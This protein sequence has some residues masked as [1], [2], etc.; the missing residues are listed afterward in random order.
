MNLS[1]SGVSLVVH[2][3]VRSPGGLALLRRAGTGVAATIIATVPVL[4][5]P[6]AIL[7]FRER[8]TLREIFGSVVAVV[9]VGL[10][11]LA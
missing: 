7:Y 4:L 8:V 1:R 3:L 10:L 9:G 6:V 5:I 11:F 2:V